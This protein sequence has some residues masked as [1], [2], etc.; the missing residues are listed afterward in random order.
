M[1]KYREYR[2]DTII[3][4]TRR[5]SMQKYQD[6]VIGNRRWGAL[7]YFELCALF[8][9]PL[10]GA[11]GLGLRRFAFKPLFARVGNGVVFGHHVSLR[12]PANISLGNNTVIDDFA[13]LSFRGTDGTQHYP[14]Q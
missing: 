9:N 3:E 1:D 13:T 11:L 6:L 12:S 10:Q 14:G 8:F 4:D 2:F 5:S 7:L